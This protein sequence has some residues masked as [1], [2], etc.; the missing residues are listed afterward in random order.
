M[1]IDSSNNLAIKAG[2]LRGQD[3]DAIQVPFDQYQV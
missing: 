1:V 2:V 3:D